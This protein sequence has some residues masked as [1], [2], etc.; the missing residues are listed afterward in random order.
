VVEIRRWVAQRAATQSIAEPPIEFSRHSSGSR[1]STQNRPLYWKSP[2]TLT[3][4]PILF[5][6]RRMLAS[7]VALTLVASSANGADTTSWNKIRYSGGTIQTKVDPYDWNTVLTVSPSAIVMVFG[8]R[9]TVR[10]AP[11][12]VTSLSYGLEAHRRV[13]EMVALSIFATPVALFGLLHKGKDHFIGIEYH[14]ENGK[15]A[16]ILLEAHKDNYK[17]VLE[18]LK[19]VTGRPVEN[20][21]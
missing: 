10:I 5:Q 18:A 17:A 12:Q 7:I 20:A 2:T 6:M 9:Q 13:A 3:R 14:G 4:M 16:S 1:C 8:H 15:P 21:P 11:A 19:T